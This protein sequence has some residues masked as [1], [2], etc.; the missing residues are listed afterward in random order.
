[1]DA[2]SFLI[3]KSK[4]SKHFA[5]WLRSRGIGLRGKTN[6]TLP[7]IA[8]ARQM[9]NERRSIDF[10][11]K[12][13]SG[14][15]WRRGWTGALLLALAAC[16]NETPPASHQ[17]LVPVA[18]LPSGERVPPIAAVERLAVRHTEGRVGSPLSKASAPLAPWL[19]TPEPERPGTRG[20]RAQ[21]GRC[22]AYVEPARESRGSRLH[23]GR[24]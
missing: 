22:T 9:S 14:R 21:H 1:M 18:S 11:R 15:G 20:G 8:Y 19:V 24:A 12:P 13:P 6:S 5:A 10:Q 3:T 2:R 4:P 23:R 16:A 7:R 17:Y